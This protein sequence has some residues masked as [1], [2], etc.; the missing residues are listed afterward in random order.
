MALINNKTYWIRPGCLEKNGRN[1]PG[2]WFLVVFIQVSVI[3]F[4]VFLPWMTNMSS[5][6]IDKKTTGIFGPTIANIDK[7]LKLSVK[8]KL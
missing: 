1:N 5:I 6:V 7:H 3:I 8:Q 2:N 4:Q